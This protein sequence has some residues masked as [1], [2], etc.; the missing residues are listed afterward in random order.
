LREKWREVE[1]QIPPPATS[2]EFMSTAGTQIEKE[3]E[4]HLW[5]DQEAGVDHV[6][7]SA[8]LLQHARVFAIKSVR[9]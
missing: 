3:K 7:H 4:M 1:G 9:S 5:R 6:H 2:L 8:Y